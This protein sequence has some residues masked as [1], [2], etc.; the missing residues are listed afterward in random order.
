MAKFDYPVHSVAEL[1]PEMDAESY[2]ALKADI[3]AHGQAEPIVLWKKQLIDGRHRLRAC[4]ELNV[5]PIVAD[6]PASDDP[7]AYVISHNLHRRHLSTSQRAMVAAKIATL[8][9]GGDRRSADQEANLPLENAAILLNV[10]PRSV[11]SANQVIEHGAKAV[12]KAVEQ[13]SLA[14]STAAELATSGATKSEQTQAVK[15][16]K[17]EIKKVLNKPA[18]TEP[19]SAPIPSAVHHPKEM[20]GP[21]MAHVKTLVQ[22]LNDLKKRAAERGGEWIDVQAISMQVSALKYSLKSSIYY[23]DCPACGG[24]RCE[25]CK[26]TGFLPELKSAVVD[27]AK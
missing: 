25:R 26:Q 22:M 13:G 5:K 7:L 27:E 20:A 8:S 9:H 17:D 1:F 12:Q 23:A 11:R 2:A 14:I 18:R 15:G 19:A 10:S 16:G 3:A 24:K 6:I 4:N 21:L